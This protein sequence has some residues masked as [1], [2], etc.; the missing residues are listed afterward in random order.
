M[1]TAIIIILAAN[2]IILD[3]YYFVINFYLHI[4]FVSLLPIVEFMVGKVIN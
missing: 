4:L 1:L 2:F 3:A